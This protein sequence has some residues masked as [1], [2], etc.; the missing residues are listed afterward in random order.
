MV[1]GRTGGNEDNSREAIYCEAGRASS[2]SDASDMRDR[3]TLGIPLRP[4]RLATS[5]ARSRSCKRRF[6]NLKAK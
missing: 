6:T 4:N 1:A 5:R 3:G 2:A